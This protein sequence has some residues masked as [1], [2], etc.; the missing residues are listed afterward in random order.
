MSAATRPGDPAR[1]VDDLMEELATAFLTPDA[2]L[3]EAV[4]RI[5]VVAPPL[6]ALL[7]RAALHGL[8][9]ERDRTLMFRAIYVLATGRVPAACGPILRFL[10][11][12]PDQVDAVLGDA[13]TESLGSIVASAYDDDADTL[14]N[15]AVDRR[16]DEAARW[17]LFAAIG[18]LTA[19]GR[20]PL[21][22]TEAFLARF[23][24]ESL[25]PRLDMA[26]VGW[27][28]CIAVLGLRA[29]APAVEQR[30]STM[31]ADMMEPRH[32]NELLADAVMDPSD[33]SRFDRLHVGFIDDIGAAFD[34]VRPRKDDGWEDG[35]RLVPERNPL[36]TVGRNDPCICG[37]GRKYKKCCLSAGK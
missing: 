15:A 1:P 36:R 25:A 16:I 37:S 27:A 23:H 20:I 33:L 8:A 30:F 13:V 31:P 14:F 5:D 32:F 18:L 9:R 26:W 12:H 2:A 28:E 10:R 11:R 34:W 6:L 17:S 29:L 22:A 24:A 19:H 4:A 21:V 3:L 7:E 35:E